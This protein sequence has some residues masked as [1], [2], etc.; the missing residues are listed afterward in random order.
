MSSEPKAVKF[1]PQE[2]TNPGTGRVNGL[3]TN[4]G[5]RQEEHKYNVDLQTGESHQK[6]EGRFELNF[7]LL[8][9]SYP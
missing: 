3:H 1:C 2:N 9:T 8:C 6:L 5:M 7:V 4:S